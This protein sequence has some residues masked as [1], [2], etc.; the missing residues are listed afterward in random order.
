[1]QLGKPGDH[2]IVGQ[3]LQLGAGDHAGPQAELVGDRAGG[4]GVVAGDHPHI[5]TDQCGALVRKQQAV[6]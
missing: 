3:V 4:D 5:S 1:V 2:H 6:G